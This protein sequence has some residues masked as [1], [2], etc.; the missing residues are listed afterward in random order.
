[1]SIFTAHSGMKVASAEYEESIQNQHRN[2]VLIHMGEVLSIRFIKCLCI[3]E[4]FPLG[5]FRSSY[6]DLHDPLI[7]V[8]FIRS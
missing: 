7:S 1:M 5:P 3:G 6:L 8:G 4:G 2:E